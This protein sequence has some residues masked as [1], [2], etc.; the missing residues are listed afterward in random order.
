[1]NFE[2]EKLELQTRVIKYATDIENGTIK[3]GK[4]TKWMVRRFFKDLKQIESKDYPFYV[5][6]NEL[7]KFNRWSGMFKH[8][9]GIL[10]GQ[11]IDLTDYQLF[12]AA[13]IFCF[14]QKVNDLRRFREVYIQVGRKNAKSQ[15]LAIVVS[16]VAFLSDEQEE[17]YISSWTREQSQL[18]Y[19]ETLS[20]IRKVDM[21]RE[22]FSDA[23]Q[24]ITVLNNGSVIKALSR[25]ARKTGD[26]TNPSL[27]VLDEYKDNQTSELRDTQKTGMVARKNPLLVV[28][29]T[30]GLDL[31]VPCYSDYQ[32]YTRILDPDDD[33]E[34][35][36]IF[37]AIYEL[38]VGDDVKDESNWIKANPIVATYERGLEALRSDLRIALEQPEKM[39]AFLTKNMNIWVDQKEDGYMDMAK[40]QKCRIQTYSNKDMKL[41][42]EGWNTYTGVDLSMTTDLTS[43]GI[44]A[45]KGG[46]FRV[47]Q[48][49]FM[50]EE[51]YRE[52]MSRDQTRY[53][54]FKE[55]GCL[56]LTPGNVVDY[57]FVKQWILDFHKDNNI[58]ENGYDKWNALHLVQELEASGITNVEI[59]Q[60]ISHLSIPTKEFRE[61]VYSGK[62]E[63]FDDPVLK[64]ALGNAVLKMDEQENVMIG[65]KVS[66]ERIDPAAGVINAFARAM[67]DNQRI[68]LNER[69]MSDDFTF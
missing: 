57:R 53:D 28:I 39:R 60:N 52:R 67:Y 19:N 36:E 13:N 62:V 37:I 1:M 8:T 61:A 33:A 45:V 46:K 7:L 56:E 20:Q 54:L 4:K 59:P 66:K 9:K 47:F 5:D 12:L 65:K 10:A 25:E 34:N 18:V 38:D 26:G 48:H 55:S 22:K 21:L 3:A 31:N 11:L 49:S 27:A 16:Y 14:K 42:L 6:W 51:N 41:L 24:K 17:I 58:L 63:H 29:T 15:F 64:W 40:W 43:V 2:E 35:E 44:V 30:A 68:D 69:I 23:Y 50:P 32:Y